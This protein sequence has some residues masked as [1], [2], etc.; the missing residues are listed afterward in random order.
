NVVAWLVLAGLLWRL[1][2]VDDA[3]GCLAWSGVMFSAGALSSV[4]FALTDLIALTV[5]A[6]AMLAAETKRRGW[7]T[8]ILA[9]AGLARET[10]LGGIVG[11]WERPWL[12]SRNI[13]RSLL[14]AAPLVA[15]VVYVR[16]RVGYNDSGFQNLTWPVVGYLEK[17]TATFAAIR[18]EN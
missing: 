16:W 11:V 14:V 2:A 8:G 5:F 6:G 3:R 18:K 1:L 9:A 13:F 15:W 4:R 12:S 17:W 7:A 10:A